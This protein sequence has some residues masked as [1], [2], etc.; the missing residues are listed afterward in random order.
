M[1]GTIDIL[2]FCRILTDLTN[3]DKCEWRPTSHKS[4]DR[5]D[6]KT[7]YIEITQYQKSDKRNKFYHIELF[8]DDDSQFI[9][10]EAEKDKEIDSEAYIVF[11]N[12]YKA[13]WNY[14]IR[15]RNEKIGSFFN[16]IMEVSSKN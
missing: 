1:Y 2:S 11:G 10:F 4:R 14:Y 3:K 12:L 7:G 9:P 8:N 13:I 16:E 5:L 15:T 6:F